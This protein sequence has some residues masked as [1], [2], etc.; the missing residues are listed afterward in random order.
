MSRPVCWPSRCG[1]RNWPWWS[2][3]ASLLSPYSTTW[4]PSC[5]P[6]AIP[7]TAAVSKPAPPRKHC[8]RRRAR[9]A[10]IAGPILHARLGYLGRVVAVER[11]PVRHA[12]V[13]YGAGRT[14][15]RHLCLGLGVFLGTGTAA[16]VHLDGG[17]PVPLALVRGYVQRPGALVE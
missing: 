12:R 3:Q 4:S 1:F 10:A 17:N 11:R 2:A 7:L 5:S 8:E 14:G 6:T 16:T 13:H 15:R 9:P